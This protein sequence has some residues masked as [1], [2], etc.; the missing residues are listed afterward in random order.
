MFVTNSFRQKNVYG[1]GSN[2]EDLVYKKFLSITEKFLKE[3]L[4]NTLV[5][6]G[7]RSRTSCSAI[8]LATTRHPNTVSTVIKSPHNS[9]RVYHTKP[10]RLKGSIAMSSALPR[11]SLTKAQVM[12]Q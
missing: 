2:I 3:N 10:A 12:A 9:R 7:N 1:F 8:S 5:Q 6:P 4:N 11:L